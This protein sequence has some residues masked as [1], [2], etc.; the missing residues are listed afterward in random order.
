MSLKTEVQY[1]PLTAER[2]DATSVEDADEESSLH[3][4]GWRG[5]L[6]IYILVVLLNLALVGFSFYVDRR[7]EREIFP[8]L[9]SLPTPDAFIGLSTSIEHGSVSASD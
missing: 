3:S 9:S 6:T 5:S 7:L 1:T 8:R 2:P 4:A